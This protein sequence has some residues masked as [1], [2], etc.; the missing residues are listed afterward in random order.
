M[1]GPAAFAGDHLVAEAYIGKGAAH[2]DFVVAAAGSIG[3]E[4]LWRDAALG[5]IF[6]GGGFLGDVASGGNV[7]GGDEISKQ[8]EDVIV[9]ASVSCIYGLGNP[10]EF[11]NRIIRLSKGMSKSRTTFLYELVNNLYSR[12]TEIF[13]RGNFRVIG[14]NV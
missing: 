5:E 10:A 11:K 3:V 2:H 14:E 7:V 8:G 9:V 6:C 13:E 1:A 4:V 12:T